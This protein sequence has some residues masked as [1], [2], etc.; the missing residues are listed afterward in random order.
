MPFE[1]MATTQDDEAGPMTNRGERRRSRSGESSD[2]DRL[3]PAEFFARDALHVARDLLGKHLRCGDVRVRI[4]EVEAYR[5]PDDSA[6]HCHRGQTARNAP[7]WGPPGRCY[8]YLCYG[9]HHLLNLVTN[10]EGQGAAVLIRGAEPVQG[11]EEIHRRRGSARGP[12]LLA[13]PG[14]VGQALG[15]DVTWSNHA[16][17][18]AG[19]LEALDAP[20]VD[21]ILVGPRVGIDYAEPE[22]RDAPWRLAVAGSPWVSHRRT[23]RGLGDEKIR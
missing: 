19:G 9:I 6:N 3:L 15:V 16:V 21:E 11:R 7:M 14:R 5:W 18:V 22:H 13:G 10:L 17:F 4:T 1:T 2:G 12:A 8:V 23:L 20:S